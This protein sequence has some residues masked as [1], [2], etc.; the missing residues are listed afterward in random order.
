L[1]KKQK[2]K[3]NPNE[4]LSHIYIGTYTAS[5]FM[6]LLVLQDFNFDRIL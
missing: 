6:K 2:Q 4:M 3:Q 5:Q 1:P